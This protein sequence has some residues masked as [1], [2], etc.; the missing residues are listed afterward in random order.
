MKDNRKV[1]EEALERIKLE[2]LQNNTSINDA[3]TNW[4]GLEGKINLL[5]EISKELLKLN[6]E[7]LKEIESVT[8]IITNKNI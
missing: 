7:I 1:I 5:S 4:V 8:K 3:E 6:N 2:Y